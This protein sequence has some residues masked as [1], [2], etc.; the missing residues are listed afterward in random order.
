M[1]LLSLPGN[2]VDMEALWM[3]RQLGVYME[4]VREYHGVYLEGIEA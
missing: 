1:M 4:D 2:M 3:T